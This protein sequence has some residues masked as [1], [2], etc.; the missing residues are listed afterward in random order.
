METVTKLYGQRDI[1]K[2]V[3]MD[4]WAGAAAVDHPIGVARLLR[5][6][7][8]E[9]LGDVGAFLPNRVPVDELPPPFGRYLSACAELSAH[10]PEERGGVRRWLER[11]FASADPAVTDAVTTLSTGEREMLMT[12][13]SALAHTYRWDRVPPTRDRFEEQRI[14][15]PPGILVPWARLARALDQPR[16]GTTWSVHLCNWK[17]ADRMGGVEYRPEELSTETLR[18]AL[19]WLPPPVDAHLERFSLSFVLLEAR[20]AVIL[21]Y[22]VEAINAAASRHLDDTFLALEDLQAAIAAMTRGFSLHVRKGTVDPE[23]WLNI[24]QP[25]FAWSAEAD[26][27]GCLAGGASGL[28]VPTIQAL[29]SALGISGESILARLAMAQRRLMPKPHRRFLRMMDLAGPVLRRFVLD[30]RCP[31]LTRQF[32][33]CIRGVISFRTVHHSRALLYLRSRP[34]DGT[35]R[36]STGLTIGVEDDAIAVVDRTMSERRLETHAAM[37]SSDDTPLPS[38]V[39]QEWSQG[40]E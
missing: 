14:V 21:H 37:L 8:E 35:A 28:Q 13:L 18:V 1:L 23:M 16:V 6:S 17:I 5:A 29:D 2:G 20:G 25:T 24:V 34:E 26:E 4:D 9:D 7:Y 12:A 40:L 3:A 39:V 15:L 31:D 30:A 27:P 10:Y 19:N 22:L 36:I 38:Q 11:E 33:S 32:N